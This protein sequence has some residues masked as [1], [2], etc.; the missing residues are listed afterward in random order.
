[1]KVDFLDVKAGYIELK[2]QIDAAIKGILESGWYVLGSEVDL[3]EKDYAKYCESEHCVGVGNGLDALHLGLLA[4][5]VGPGDEVI[6]PSNTYIATWLAVS[7]CGAKPVPVEPDINT[8]NI[9]PSSIADAITEKTKVIIPVHLYGQSADLDPILEIAKNHGLK[10]LEDAAQVHGGRYKGRRIGAH[11]DLV[12]WSFYPGKNLGALGDAGAITCRNK[13]E[14]L[15]LKAF[16]NYG[17][18]SKYLHNY[19][20]FN[21]RLDTIQA[22]ILD[23]KLKKLDFHNNIRKKQASEYFSSFEKIKEL[24][25]LEKDSFE[26]SSVWHLFPIRTSLRDNLKDYLK[27][28]GVNTLIHYPVPIMKQKVFSEFNFSRYSCPIGNNAPSRLLS[29][30]IGPHLSMEDIKQISNLIEKFY[31]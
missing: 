9:A 26:Y 2:P 15:K 30:P 20:G 18:E 1:M 14:Y 17:S 28:N 5:G 29:L 4:L 16:S 3:F 25:L 31:K 21:A 22:V 6:V 12:A 13:E 19:E 24:Q 10:V 8:F 7:Q 23:I 11:G 27:V